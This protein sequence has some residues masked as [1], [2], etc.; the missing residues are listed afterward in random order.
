MR[1]LSYLVVSNSQ[2]IRNLVV[3]ILKNAFGIK[4]IVQ[5]GDG[6]KALK[7][8]HSIPIDMIISDWNMPGMDGKE[9]LAAMHQER[10]LKKTPFIMITSNGE[11]KFILHAMELGVTDYVVK[12]FTPLDLEKKLRSAWAAS[13]KRMKERYASL[14]THTTTININGKSVAATI[15][16][17]SLTGVLLNV[18]HTDLFGL[19]QNC[20]LDIQ[21]E[22]ICNSRIDIKSLH[23]TSVRL[24]GKS[25]FDPATGEIDPTKL[26]YCLVAFCFHPKKNESKTKSAL[27][28][29]IEWL[30][31]R[32]PDKIDDPIR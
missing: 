29:L 17:I 28:E 16:N 12:P 18:W 8:L 15:E 19:Y 25:P 11:M 6:E 21:V 13:A 2:V 7:V 26:K 5:A 4:K 31:S 32:D 23:A 1:D 10:A 24:E 30:A 14:P 27:G 22:N 3:N 9:L 20:M